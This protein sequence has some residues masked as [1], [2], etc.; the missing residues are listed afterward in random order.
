[1]RQGKTHKKGGTTMKKF[2]VTNYL[3]TQDGW[4]PLTP[5]ISEAESLSTFFTPNAGEEL[6]IIIDQHDDVFVSSRTGDAIQY[7]CLY[8][9][10]EDATWE[11]EREILDMADDIAMSALHWVR[12]LTCP[13]A[14]ELP[15]DVKGK[16]RLIQ[17]V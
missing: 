1:M 15:E 9:I 7:Y 14:D 13:L 4:M 8:G 2:L 11:Q 10:P 6:D 12:D 3:S 16:A 17:T 5:H